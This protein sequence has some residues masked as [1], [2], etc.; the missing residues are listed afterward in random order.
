MT[1]RRRARPPFH[2]LPCALGLSLLTVGCVSGLEIMRQQQALRDSVEQVKTRRGRECAPEELARAEANLAFARI[3]MKEGD[4]IRAKEH[5]ETGHDNVL[6]AL[7]KVA[8]CTPVKTAPTPPPAPRDTDR[9]GIVDAQDACPDR[10]EDFDGI[11]DDDGCPEA[12]RDRDG[13]GIMDELDRCPDLPED[14]D[15]VE[16]DDGCPDVSDDRDGDGLA[17]AV[18]RCPDQPEDKDGFQDEDGC[19]DVDNDGDGLFDVVDRCPLEA[20][21]IDGFED[22]D[23]CPDP[24]NDKDGIP[25][26]QDRCPTAAEVRN[27]YEDEDGCPDTR[28][29]LPSRVTLTNQQ[30]RISE[31]IKFKL[32]S[33]VILKESYGILDDVAKVLK[34]YPRIKIRVEGHTDDQGSEVYNLDLSKRRATS[35]LKYLVQ[36]G[37]G[38]DRLKSVGLGEGQPLEEGTSEKARANNR[39]VEFHILEQ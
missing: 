17:D 12:S 35:V 21:D 22:Q 9:D 7:K 6:A 32:N 20:E 5:L 3:E 30:L 13:D 39:R 25:D 4:P 26:G 33:D 8:A 15:G 23:G 19:P 37:V 38:A 27:A 1:V 29:E 28:P 24:D 36:G 11:E 2:L 34:A 16:D 14:K 10:P 18:D 31:Q